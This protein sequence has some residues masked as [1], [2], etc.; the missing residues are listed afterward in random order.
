MNPKLIPRPDD[1]RPEVPSGKARPGAVERVE[2]DPT[3][4]NRRLE[5]L[6]EAL[7]Q[8]VTLDPVKSQSIKEEIFL[9]LKGL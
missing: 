4:Y 6:F 8:N 3:T 7:G 9:R 1:A 2:I 5:A